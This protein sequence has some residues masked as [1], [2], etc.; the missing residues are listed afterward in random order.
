MSLTNTSNS[1]NLLKRPPLSVLWIYACGQLGWSL[2]S[3]GV[4]SLLSYFYM[5]PEDAGAKAVFPNFLPTVSILGLTLL[6]IISF[7][8]RLFDA[9]ID[10][11]VAN[12]SDKIQSNFG[13]RKTFMAIAALPLAVCSY[14]MFHPITEGGTSTN[15][16]WL[17][18]V[19]FVFY[20]SLAMY[21]IPYAALIS[22][23][24]HVASDRLKIST[25]I[26]ITW[27]L[28]FLIGNTTPALQGFFESKGDPSVLAF[29]KTVGI[30]AII[31]AVF[32]L[33]PVFF[34][35]EK[36]YALQGESHG[37]FLK[38]IQSV[39]QNRPFRYFVVSY[40]LYW[41]ALTFIQAG[42]IFY[43]TLLLGLD[44]SSATLFGIGSFFSSFL[45]YPLMNKLE[46]GFSKKTVILAAFLTFIAI[47]CI[48]LM[49][50]SGTIRFWLVTVLAAFPLAAFGILPNTIVA[51]CIHENEKITGKNQAGMFYAVAAFMMKVGISLANLIFPS[52]LVYGKSVDNPLGVQLTIVAALVF[53]TAGFFVF[54]KYEGS[55]QAT[56]GR[57]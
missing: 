7:S 20:I 23:L 10:P 18:G 16:I 8:G 31:A 40:L 27:A 29:Q 2:A 1:V 17:T 3:Y 39:L 55:Y 36:K 24:G 57:H 43:V 30:F 34:L 4:G 46:K 53:C 11:F 13:K 25:I 6:G 52:L 14:L 45:F 15:M 41:L 54:R 28:G 44:K 47:F 5:P 33:I 19:V 48:L 50:I 12:W 37:N 9:F 21:M 32:L 26:S 35:N 56:G 42:I 38:A 22:E 51:D 49:P